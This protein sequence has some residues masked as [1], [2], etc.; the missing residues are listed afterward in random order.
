MSLCF[1][2]FKLPVL[3]L[4]C[5]LFVFCYCFCFCFYKNLFVCL[6]VFGI[7]FV[8]VPFL[9]PNI[10]GLFVQLGCSFL[11]SLMFVYGN[12]HHSNKTNY[13]R[14][15]VNY[16]IPCH[17]VYNGNIMLHPPLHLLCKIMK[18]VELK[19]CLLMFM[20]E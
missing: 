10:S 15:I 8:L 6:F 3:F 19:N 9:V 12:F 4:L 18:L 1:S 14:V 13:V 2:P 11:F 7:L 17:L 16:K 20:Y 5:W